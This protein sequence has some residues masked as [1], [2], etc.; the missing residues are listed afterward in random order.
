MR[1]LV[2]EGI[3]RG[4]MV[5]LLR[6]FTHLD[7]YEDSLARAGLQPYVVGGRGY[8]SQQQVSD[9]CALLA[10]LANPLDDQALFGALASPAC[11]VAP[12]TLWLLRAAVGAGA[13]VWPA[14]ERL[15]G[16]HEA[17]VEAPERLEQ[18]PE[19]E[20]T[21]LRRFATT[22]VELRERKTRLPLAD[23]I[24][25][26]VTETGYDLAILLKPAGEA[27]FANVRKLMQIAEEFERREGRDLRGLLDFLAFREDADDES[28]AATAAEG[29]D[30]VRIMSIHRAKG[31]EFGVVAV[32][33]LDRAL[34]PGW[35]PLL[36]FGR[37]EDRRVGMQLRRLG[38]RS[39]NLYAH[40]ELCETEKE[41]DAEEGLRLFHVAA[42]RAREHLILSGVVKE[43]P[44]EE[45]LSTPVIERIVERLGIDR[46]KGSVVQIPA[47]EPR[48]GLELT[49][50]PSEM[51]VRVNPPER[52][53]ELVER[54]SAP[55][56]ASELGE[57]PAP[58]RERRPRAVPRHRLSYSALSDYRECGYRFQMERIFGFGRTVVGGGPAADPEA[59]ASPR[60]ERSARG[61]V[62]HA[63]LEWSHANGWSEPPPDLVRQHVLGEG[64]DPGSDGLVDGLLAS[65]RAWLGSDLFRE[66]VEGVGASAEVPLTLDVADSVLRGSIDLLVEGDGAPPLV[67]DYKTDRLNGSSP[68]EHVARYEI[69]RTIYGLAVAEARQAGEVEVAYVFLERPDQ[70]VRST[71]GPAEMERGRELLAEMIGEI[72]HG[73]FPAAAPERRSW[74]LCRG[75]PVLRVACSGPGR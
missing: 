16:I 46:G 69:Q 38:S 45:K 62:T 19:P 52:V 43:K 10:V 71:L 17:S 54:R 58:L 74:D 3:P 18:I 25:R 73:S 72:A 5:V 53:A 28:A 21:L 33:H 63:L 30:G 31:L 12:D 40:P 7:A 34:L 23:L 15:A 1:E 51:A 29:H 22:V 55:S 64:L 8:W 24:D 14:L 65:V 68:Q 36:T 4:E 13:H 9:V 56:T 35:P 66:R 39:I 57:G 48:Q 41:R 42:T 60:E 59:S 61:R 50:E 32:P 47:P 49:F 70:P 11:A 6:A 2:D 67:I 27:R 75:C 20:L 26:A 44:G 37:G